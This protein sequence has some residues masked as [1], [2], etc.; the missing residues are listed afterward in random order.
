MKQILCILTCT[1]NIGCASTGAGIGI[2]PTIDGVQLV[3]NTTGM[4]LI[5]EVQGVARSHYWGCSGLGLEAYK[6]AGKAAKAAGANRI[7]RPELE[8]KF[9]FWYLY[10]GC[11]ATVNAGAFVSPE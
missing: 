4:E 11:T 8:E 3:E 6:I 9:N 10:W 1:L 2:Y 5:G 7:S